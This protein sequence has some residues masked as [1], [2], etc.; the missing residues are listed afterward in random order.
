M[1][2]VSSV[3]P[4][5]G[6]TY[7]SIARRSVSKF[8][9]LSFEA[10]HG[11]IILTL[12]MP[13]PYDALASVLVVITW[14][15]AIKLWSQGEILGPHLL[16][17]STAPSLLTNGLAWMEATVGLFIL[18]STLSNDSVTRVYFAVALT[19]SISIY[20]GIL[21]PLLH[22]TDF[23]HTDVLDLSVLIMLGLSAGATLLEVQAMQRDNPR[24]RLYA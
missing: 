12:I 1:V 21:Q 3:V 13:L 20:F 23:E 22:N 4:K 15:D 6:R 14:S 7:L 2:P 10:N 9:I 8:Q 18:A 16:W 5:F 11:I 17:T 24:R 19:M